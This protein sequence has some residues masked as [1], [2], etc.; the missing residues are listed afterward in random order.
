LSLPLQPKILQQPIQIRE[1]IKYELAIPL[2]NTSR[3]LGSP[4][5]FVLGEQ[6]HI[7]A[8]FVHAEIAGL[9]VRNLVVQERR[10]P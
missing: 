6:H 5:S 8:D 1:A 3:D 2:A 10:D 9:E 7:F 4:Q